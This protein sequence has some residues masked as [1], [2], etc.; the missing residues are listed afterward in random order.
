MSMNLEVW[1][2]EFERIAICDN[3]ES[4]IWTDRYDGY[5]DFELYFGMTR[6][7]LDIYKPD[8]YLIS[9]DSEYIMIIENLRIQTDTESGNHLVITGRSLESILTRRIIW[10]QT[11]V[12]GNLQNAIKR[13]ITENVINPSIAN[14]K[15][16]NFIFN[17]STDVTVTSLTIEETQFTGD[18][19]Y[20]AIQAICQ[21][22]DLGF[23]LIL[24]DNYQFVFTL[25]SGIDRSY[26]QESL[27]Y[28]VFSPDFENIINSDYFEA[29]ESYSN[30]TLVAGE[31]EGYDRTTTV[32]GEAD[33]TELNRREYFTDARDLSSNVDGGTLTPAQYLSILKARG[34]EKLKEVEIQKEFEGQVEP[35]QM[36]RYGEHFF[37]GDITELENEFGLETRVRVIEYIHSES[38]SGDEEYPT[39]KVLDSKIEEEA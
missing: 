35:T 13:L 1:N 15:I 7:L 27:P 10:N 36:Y 39:F 2:T 19:L 32:V 34:E 29:K 21:V 8:Y 23:K 20:D 33:S 4:M 6:A 3:Y 12:S 37:M 11:T 18:T 14:R 30:V 31:G 25:Y 24:N 28:V 16:S 17:E 22:H 9:D 26:Q 5:G 38:T